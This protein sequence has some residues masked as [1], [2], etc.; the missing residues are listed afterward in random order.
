MDASDTSGFEIKIPECAVTGIF[1]AHFQTDYPLTPRCS[2][3]FD[4]GAVKMLFKVKDNE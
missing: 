2:F 3:F 4:L 1:T